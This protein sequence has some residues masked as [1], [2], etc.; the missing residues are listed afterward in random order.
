MNYPALK[1]DLKK[2]EANTRLLVEKCAAYN[3]KVS[4]VTKAFCGIPEVAEAMVKGGAAYLADSRVENLIKMKHIKQPKMLLRI[5]MLS[6]VKEVV[7][8]ADI[9]LNS[10]YKVIKALSDEAQEKRKC[11]DIILM[12]DLGDLREGVWA[13][14]AVEYAGK[15][16]KLEGVR[17]IGIGTNLTC[18]GAV[19]PKVDNLSKLV[20]IAENIEKKYGVKLSIISGGNSSSYYLVENGTIPKGINNLRLGESVVLGNETAYG[21]RIE[22]TYNDCFTLCAEIIELKEKPSVPIGEIGVDAFGNKPTY[23]DRG[24]RKRAIL[25]IGKQDVR[26]DGLTP[27]DKKIIIL[28]ASSDHMIVDVTDS[29]TDYSIG[30]II[31]FTM[32]Y[33]ALLSLSTSDYVYKVIE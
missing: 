30:D 6:Q 18:Y 12:V 26:I 8:Y 22:G 23:V 10:E 17:L 2:I 4:A 16:I 27:I 15:I 25:A 33:G 31:E 3:I 13:D 32:D 20:E 24:I 5:P 1:I 14:E 21:N 29:E 19:I 7:E 28:G 9:S 11:H